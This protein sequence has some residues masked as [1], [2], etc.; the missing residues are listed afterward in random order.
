MSTRLVHR[1]ARPLA[2]VVDTLWAQRRGALPHAREALLP[3][4]CA[5]LVI[6]LHDDPPS[7]G[8]IGAET[9][10]P[11]RGGV[12]QA[13]GDAAWWRGTGGAASDVVGVHFRPGGATALLGGLALELRDG[14][15]ALADLD[16]G[17]REL[18]ERLGEEPSL[19]RRLAL[20][21]AELTARLLQQAPPA[22]DPAIDATIAAFVGGATRVEAVQRASGLSPARF[23]ER[24]TRRVGLPPKRFARVQRLEALLRGLAAPGAI[25][26]AALA[27]D[28]GFADQ[29][30]LAHEFRRMT[31][32]TPTAYRAA[33]PRDVHHL[34]LLR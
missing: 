18:R 27:L 11:M 3:T 9:L 29:A 12:L 33:A 31:G 32:S 25:D 6:A 16:A 8:A 19:P 21:D 34:P 7:R 14:V 17:W 1:P 15:V 4:G 22:T 24:F 5:D 28:A 13:A 10:L 2:A 20:L 26:L 23:S 30:H